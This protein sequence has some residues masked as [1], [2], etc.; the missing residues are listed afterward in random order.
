M[1]TRH[2]RVPGHILFALAV[3]L[4]LA[5]PAPVFA[6]SESATVAAGHADS[7]FDIANE[8]YKTGNY[9]DAITLY[10]SLLSGREL[11]TADVHYNIG[12][13]S[14]KLNEY[15]RAIASYRRALRLSPRDQDIIANL[16]LARSV[17][18]DKMDQPKNTEFLREVFFFHYGLSASEIEAAFLCAYLAAALFATACLFRKV[19]FVQWLA[20]IALFLSAA[21]GA[22]LGLRWYRTAN[23]GEAVVV[24]TEADIHTGPG[25]NY[26]VSLNLHDGAELT[27]RKSEGEW[28][29]VELPDGR[30]GW[31]KASMIE[32]I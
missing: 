21:F 2:R 31:V 4:L 5:W 12:N 10:E 27:V 29:Q 9:K 22:S 16:R 28:R 6:A 18:V 20:L 32:M 26:I 15:G 14:Y 1:K 7:V 17:T 3:S 23:P 30:R 8:E 11:N 25:H 13:A 24:S 19:R